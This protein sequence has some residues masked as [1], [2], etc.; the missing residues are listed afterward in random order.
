MKKEYLTNIP[1]LGDISKY[2]MTEIPKDLLG[3]SKI[4]TDEVYDK[5]FWDKV[6]E[7]MRKENED[8]ERMCRNMQIDPISG[9]S[10]M[11]YEERNRMFTL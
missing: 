4:Q 8:Y 6:A 5:E 3:F 10:T 1:D 2:V 11:S 9:K 7:S